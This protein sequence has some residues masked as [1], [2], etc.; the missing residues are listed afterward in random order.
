M[1]WGTFIAADRAWLSRFY[2]GCFR[3]GNGNGR[4]LDCWLNGLREN[5]PDRSDRLV[6]EPVAA[7]LNERLPFMAEESVAGIPPAGQVEKTR[8]NPAPSATSKTGTLRLRQKKSCH[9]QGLFPNLTIKCTVRC[10]LEWIPV[11]ENS[12]GKL[13]SKGIAGE[14]NEFK[15]TYAEQRFSPVAEPVRRPCAPENT[16][17]STGGRSGLG[18]KST[19]VRFANIAG[20]P[21]ENGR[22]L[23]RIGHTGKASAS[24]PAAG[25]AADF[26]KDRIC[27]EFPRLGTP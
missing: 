18:L 7:G 8:S 4:L 26:R 23:F 22:A 24:G 14:T 21:S 13:T 11:P 3:S 17:C 19:N 25:F 6:S 9:A 15:G 12:Y 27:N 2:A 10:R 16:E 5:D 1:G 20:I